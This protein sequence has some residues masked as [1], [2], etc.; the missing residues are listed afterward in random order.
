[1][2]YCTAPAFWLSR[3]QVI[4]SS[5]SESIIGPTVL[6]AGAAGDPIRG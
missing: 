2:Y 6:A 5:K 3:R 1:L 4:G